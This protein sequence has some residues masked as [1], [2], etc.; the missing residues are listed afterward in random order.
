MASGLKI[1]IITP[2]FNQAQYLPE[3]IESVLAQNY[4]E[5]EYIIIDGGSTDGSVDVIRKYEKHLAYWIS[6]PDRGQSDAI[7]KGLKK[8][9]GEV[10]NWLN[11]DD[12]LEPHA[13]KTIAQEFEDPAVLAVAARSNVVKDRKV[14]YRSKGTDIYPGNLAKTI[15]CARV[16]QPETF[17]RKSAYD[18]IGYINERFHYIMDREWWIRFLIEYGLDVVRK[19]DP[20]IVNF[21]LHDQSKTGS[22][23]PKFEEEHTSL[24]YQLAVG[25]ALLAEAEFIKETF[26]FAKPVPIMLTLKNASV[27]RQAIHYFILQKADEAYYRSNFKLTKRIL[28][29]I[30]SAG[31]DEGSIRL[32]KKLDF[33]TQFIPESLIR[34]FRK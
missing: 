22:Q 16:D 26:P 23:A 27:I 2:S 8:A 28:S 17:F 29:F 11:S 24:F 33:R 18:R 5:K 31:M 30:E 12:Y 14:L 7:N 19:I 10:V 20:V 32:K 21:R 4:A 1:S 34:L 9:S 25:H 6:E 3:T 15:G 13:L